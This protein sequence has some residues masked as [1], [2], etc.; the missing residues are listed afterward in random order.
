M[1][2]VKHTLLHLPHSHGASKYIHNASR[3]EWVSASITL[4]KA[5]IALQHC[6][7]VCQAKCTLSDLTVKV[8]HD[9]RQ[10]MEQSKSAQGLLRIHAKRWAA[11]DNL[12]SYC[13]Q[14]PCFPTPVFH[15]VRTG[16]EL[17]HLTSGFWLLQLHENCSSAWMLHSTRHRGHSLGKF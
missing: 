8:L 9:H 16:F 13:A 2:E 3:L 4:A 6:F 5:W 14:L 11:F 15:F 10:T 17:K 12:I 7:E 1:A